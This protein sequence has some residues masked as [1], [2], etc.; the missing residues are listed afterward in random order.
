M[1]DIDQLFKVTEVIS[2]SKRS[3]NVI[4]YTI[5][6]ITR[7]QIDLEWP[8]VLYGCILGRSQTSKKMADIDLLFKVTEVISRSQ[9]SIYVILYTLNA[10]T[11]EKNL[12]RMTKLVIWMHLSKVPD[13]FETE[14]H[15]PIWLVIAWDIRDISIH[16]SYESVTTA[17]TEQLSSDWLVP[18]SSLHVCAFHFIGQTCTFW[19]LANTLAFA[20]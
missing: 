7:E 10:I 14:W 8:N 18:L 6:V 13:K 9:R 4:L 17:L 3:I 2:S 20:G 5:R 11:R 19:Q 15:W 12:P 16:I 1:A